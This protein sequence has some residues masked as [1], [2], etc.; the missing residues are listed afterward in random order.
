MQRILGIGNAL[1]DVIVN[2]PD[3]KLLKAY[4]LPKGGMQMIDAEK[5]RQIHTAI[6]ELKQTLASGGSTSNTI[7]GLARLGASTGYIGKMKW[8]NFLNQICK[9]VA[10]SH[11]SFTHRRLTQASPP[12]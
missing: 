5:K 3:E 2:L 12:H 4:E 10:S 1:V 8:A 6:R 11:I 7:H 9:K